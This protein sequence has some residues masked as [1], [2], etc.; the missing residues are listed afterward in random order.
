MKNDWDEKRR[1]EEFEYE[2]RRQIERASR[3]LIKKEQTVQYQELQKLQERQELVAR[4]EEIN[5]RIEETLRQMQEKNE[6]VS[7]LIE[8]QRKLEEEEKRKLTNLAI[9]IAEQQSKQGRVDIAKAAMAKE[10]EDQDELDR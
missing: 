9:Q 5:R 10:P 6:E 3:N 4:R 1:R 2:R 8:K 7:R